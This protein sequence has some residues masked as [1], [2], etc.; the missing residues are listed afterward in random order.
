MST[1]QPDHPVEPLFTERWSPRAFD[2]SVMP[3][4][5]LFT[6]F[7]A[8]RWAPSAFNAQPWRLL[9]AKRESADW[10]RFVGLLMP[11]N[12]VW[13][14]NASV[15]AYILSDTLFEGT[16]GEAGAVAHAQL[17]CRR[18]VGAM[19]LQATALGYHAHGMA[20]VEWDEVRTELRVPERFR[21]EAGLAIGRIASP[22]TLD[23]KLRARE[24]PSGRMPIGAFAFAGDFPS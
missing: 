10:E 13:A 21:V 23:E 15:L 11:F 2:R 6:V 18:G 19:A 8:A 9:Y 20:G 4:A 17:R 14:R 22:D 1:R 24:V 7:E 5:D 12:Q 16:D 3:D